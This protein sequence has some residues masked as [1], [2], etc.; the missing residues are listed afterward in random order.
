MHAYWWKE[1]H[2]MLEMIGT[3]F[4]WIVMSKGRRH[5]SWILTDEHGSGLVNINSASHTLEL[6]L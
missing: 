1:E 4:H 3:F 2:L 6:R 5:R